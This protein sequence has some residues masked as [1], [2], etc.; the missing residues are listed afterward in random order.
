MNTAK[1]AG[2]RRRVNASFTCRSLPA[3]D[4]PRSL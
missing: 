3:G 1:L 2:A 4:R